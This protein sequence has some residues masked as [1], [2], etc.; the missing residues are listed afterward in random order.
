MRTHR[1]PG[2]RRDPHG[3]IRTYV[4]AN[5]Q[6]RL[7]RFPA[8]TSLGSVR[9]WHTNPTP[10]RQ[11]ATELADTV[12]RDR[13][14]EEQQAYVPTTDDEDSV[15]VSEFDPDE[16]SHPGPTVRCPPNAPAIGEVK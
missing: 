13:D 11:L 2:I 14:L 16:P 8:G 12:T 6:L 15:G 4:C 1:E 3:R 7:K 5:G 9:R 10:S